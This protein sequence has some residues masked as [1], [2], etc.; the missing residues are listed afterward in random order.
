MSKPVKGSVPDGSAPREE[1]WL[2]V[3]V[4]VLAVVAV[5]VARVLAIVVVELVVGGGAADVV[6]V[7]ELELGGGGDEWWCFGVGWVPPSGSTYC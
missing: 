3:E 2:E 4:E 5:V 7:L 6:G 1:E